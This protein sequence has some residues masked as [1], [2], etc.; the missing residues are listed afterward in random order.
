MNYVVLAAEVP[1][2]NQTN[3]KRER[4]KKKLCKVYKKK[5]IP[6]FKLGPLIFR[7]HANWISEF[8]YV[9]LFIRFCCAVL[10]YY[11]FRLHT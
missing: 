2:N 3:A 9:I 4:K 11:L 10:Y 8:Y 6:L 7:L 5:Q 1:T